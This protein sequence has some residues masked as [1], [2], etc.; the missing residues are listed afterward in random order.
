MSAGP[1]P[2][3]QAVAVVFAAVRGCEIDPERVDLS[4]PLFEGGGFPLDGRALDSLEIAEALVTLE[5]ELRIEILGRAR[6]Q[7]LGS[8]EAVAEFLAGVSDPRRLVAFERKW[9]SAGLSTAGAL[10][11]RPGP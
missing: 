11:G 10:P 2:L 1:D 3:E 6:A 4:V 8:I 9:L 7:D 5:R